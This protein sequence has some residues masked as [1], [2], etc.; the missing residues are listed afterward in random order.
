MILEK[1]SLDR[2]KVI[3]TSMKITDSLLLF[4]ANS[5]KMMK[6]IELNLSS[7]EKLT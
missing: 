6:T 4:L 7:C 5:E 3:L 1:A 2:C